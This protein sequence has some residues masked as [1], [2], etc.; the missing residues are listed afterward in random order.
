MFLYLLTISLPCFFPSV[1]VKYDLRGF[2]L[3]FV[4]VPAESIAGGY[5]FDKN[6]IKSVLFSL[7]PA[8]CSFVLCG[9][10]EDFFEVLFYTQFF[11]WSS[12]AVFSLKMTWFAFAEPLFAAS[13][14]IKLMDFLRTSEAIFKAG[15]I[16]FTALL[17]L[18]PAV[19]LLY[20][21]ALFCGASGFK[22]YGSKKE[23]L[24]FAGA[25]AALLISALFLFPEDFVSNR[26]V[27]NFSD[28]K[29]LP[30]AGGAEGKE[31]L[32]TLPAEKWGNRSR[33]SSG[34]GKQYAV[35]IAASKREE[36]YGAYAYLA[37]FDPVK[38]FIE[39]DSYL[40]ELKESRFPEIWKNREVN[41]DAG[42]EEVPL[43]YIS[44]LPDR[45]VPY[46]PA[47][48]E[49][50][51]YNRETYPFSYSY[52]ALSYIS[53]VP[54]PLLA[55]G[56]EL[57]DAEK[58]ALSE[59][60]KIDIPSDFAKSFK[61]FIDKNVRKEES[62]VKKVYG[63]LSGFS[64]YRYE[65][66]MDDDSSVAAVAGFLS[67]TK[68]G[69]CTEFS[70]AA[71]MLGRMCG[72][73]SR[74]VVGYLASKDLQT[75][76]HRRGAAALQKTIPALSSYDAGDLILITTAHKHSW[77]QFYF[78]DYGWIDFE[79][80]SGAIP[81]VMDPNDYQVVIPEI[82]ERSVICREFDFPLTFFLILFSGLFAAALFFLYLFKFVKMYLLNKRAENFDAYAAGKYLVIKGA[83]A[84]LKIKSPGD[85]FREYAVFYPA[86]KDFAEYYTIIRYKEN[87]SGKSG[88]EKYRK[89]F[90]ESYLSASEKLSP[91][92]FKAVIK[93]IFSLRGIFY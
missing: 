5:F 38:G 39:E 65:L 34:R 90:L 67:E 31:E 60:L 71:A 76:A 80:T 82:S 74:V 77:V 27:L 87:Y 47:A 30:E 88:S 58:E 32:F 92:G 46:F 61:D 16:Y 86:L 44:V 37:L 12:A 25:F 10:S 79:S 72:I 3:W 62:S 53:S 45:V 6:N 9:F 1:I 83:L 43:F 49:P 54:P 59:Y 75:D 50:T 66:G 24:I 22:K 18:L 70:N 91:K 11:F 23:F 93:Y 84:G 33:S 69:D 57:T 13:V 40:N 89:L 55:A 64:S 26:F 15:R 42:R 17:I 73:P 14:Y 8:L 85:T 63:I 4:A 48:I 52:N 20:S 78:A 56:R 2:L 19:Y 41:S 68:R 7:I 81:P 36:L 35:M 21:A 29:A 28:E 51:V